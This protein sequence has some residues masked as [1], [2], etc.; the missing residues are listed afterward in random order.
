MNAWVVIVP[1][2]VAIAFVVGAGLG[3]K[4]T[5]G[6]W[7]TFLDDDMGEMEAGELL[8]RFEKWQM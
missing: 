8:D 2:I 4:W 5:T 3:V 7:I 6:I 1:V